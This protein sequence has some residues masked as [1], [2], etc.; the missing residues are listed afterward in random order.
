MIL[1][2][3]RHGQTDVRSSHPPGDPRLTEIGRQQAKLLGER[4]SAD[5]FQG[6]ILSSPYLRTTE[7]A[8][9]IAEVTTSV[10]LPSAE[11]REYVIREH[12]MDEFDGADLE[13]LVSEYSCVRNERPLPTPWWTDQLET[14]EDIEARV[15]PLIEDVI[16]AG[17]DALL[18]GHGASVAGVHRYI[19]GQYA[20]ENIPGDQVGW[21]CMLSSFRIE[22]GFEILNIMDVSHLPDDHVTNNARTRAEVMEERENENR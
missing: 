11:M 5:G 4:L 14:D 8:Q 20:P 15:R 2:V 13:T 17:E 12:Q 19:L 18:V 7:T 3:T 10:I 22:P 6:E 9:V 21:N 1:H 16:Q